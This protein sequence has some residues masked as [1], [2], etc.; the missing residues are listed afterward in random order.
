MYL[1]A[2]P[3]VARIYT[4]NRPSA[5]AEPR[6]REKAAFRERGLPEDALDDPRL[7]SLAGEVTPDKFG[8]DDMQY[9]EVLGTITHVIHN[10]WTVNFNLAL[11]SF[12]DHIGSAPTRTRR[13]R[14]RR[15]AACA[16]ARHVERRSRE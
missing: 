10:A 8:L 15:A 4:L 14:C 1:L 2:E 16:P 6:A 7:V 12:E 9:A 3:R 13:R 11:Q 5:S